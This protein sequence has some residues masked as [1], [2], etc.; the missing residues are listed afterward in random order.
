MKSNLYIRYINSIPNTRQI[1]RWAFCHLQSNMARPIISVVHIV[2]ISCHNQINWHFPVNGW[3]CDTTFLRIKYHSLL[4]YA[5]YTLIWWIA[6]VYW[7]GYFNSLG[8][9][10][11]NYISRSYTF[12]WNRCRNWYGYFVS[13]QYLVSS[14]FGLCKTLC[15]YNDKDVQLNDN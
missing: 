10:L 15:T 8:T 14:L 1:S 7:L 12:H 3:K 6:L 4:L 2:D 5:V 11:S 13:F 9:P